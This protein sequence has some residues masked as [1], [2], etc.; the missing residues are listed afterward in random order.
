MPR[1]S[2]PIV[3]SASVLAALHTAEEAFALYDLRCVHFDV[4]GERKKTDKRGDGVSY[5]TFKGTTLGLQTIEAYVV[6]KKQASLR[7][8]P[9]GVDFTVEPSG[10]MGMKDFSVNY[11][12]G[13]DGDNDHYLIQ[14]LAHLRAVALSLVAE[15]WEK[16]RGEMPDDLK[17]FGALD[18]AQVRV[19]RWRTGTLGWDKRHQLVI[20]HLLPDLVG[21]PALIHVDCLGE[22]GRDIGK[23]IF[24]LKGY[25]AVFRWLPSRGWVKLEKE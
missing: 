21:L 7:W 8:Q 17:I 9:V 24:N 2:K 6:V 1:F 20:F 22:D 10:W 18:P 13:L 5:V 12:A 16:Y 23:V 25:Y 14:D 19:L 15:I 4:L 11:L 3:L